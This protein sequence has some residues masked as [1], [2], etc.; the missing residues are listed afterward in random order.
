MYFAKLFDG[1]RQD[2]GDEIEFGEK[3]INHYESMGIDPATKAVIFS[4]ALTIKKCVTI[5]DHFRGKIKDG[6]GVG[7]H[8]SNDVGVTPM[9]MVIKLSGIYDQNGELIH[10]VKLSDDKEKNTSDSVEAIENCKFSLGL[11]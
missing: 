1:V 6:Y 7:T 8:F 2:S 5:N 3:F 11:Q 4:N 10:A 9:N